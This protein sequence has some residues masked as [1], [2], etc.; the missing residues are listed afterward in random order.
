MNRYR[1]V[2]NDNAKSNNKEYHSNNN[3]HLFR[4]H[5][6]DGNTIMMIIS[7]NNE[8]IHEDDYNNYSNDNKEIDLI[9]PVMFIEIAATTLMGIITTIIIIIITA[10]KLLLLMVNVN[11]DNGNGKDNFNR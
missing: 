10:A 11:N 6:S 2:W 4:C 9:I 5:D 1:Y 8:N 3:H 7:I